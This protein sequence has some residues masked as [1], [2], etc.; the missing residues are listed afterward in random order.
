[1]KKETI[2]TIA[3]VCCVAFVCGVILGIITLI[4]DVNTVALK[5]QA[6]ERGYAH[7][8]VDSNGNT[9]FEWNDKAPTNK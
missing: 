9:T 2:D 3:M 7:Y 6:V 1:M 4:K 5:K 8:S